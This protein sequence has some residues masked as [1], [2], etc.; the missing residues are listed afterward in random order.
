MAEILFL[1]PL[2]VELIP[3]GPNPPTKNHI[4]RPPGMA[5]VPQAKKKKDTLMRQ[6]IPGA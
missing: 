4:V 5:Q 6:D 2:E 3:C 1:A